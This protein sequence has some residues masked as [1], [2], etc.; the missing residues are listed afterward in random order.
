MTFRVV[1][2]LSRE[3]GTAFANDTQVRP[4]PEDVIAADVLVP[5]TPT[6]PPVAI[7]EDRIESH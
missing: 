6:E 3:E 7:H 1:P 4:V 5:E 2:L